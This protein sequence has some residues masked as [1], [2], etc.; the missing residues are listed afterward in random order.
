MAS[1]NNKITQ[2]KFTFDIVKKIWN[3]CK[4]RTIWFVES[5]IKFK[6]NILAE[7]ESRKLRGSLEWSLYDS[8]F[9]KHIR[10]FDVPENH[11][12]ASQIIIFSRPNI[13]AVDAFP[14][15]WTRLIDCKKNR[16]WKSRRSFDCS[17]VQN[18]NLVS[19]SNKTFNKDASKAKSNL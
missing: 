19:K 10:T 4:D 5:C 14:I 12:F 8:A 1:V 11:L 15:I 3:F 18:S 2:N 13:F 9:K 16:K 17:Y 6:G 7:T